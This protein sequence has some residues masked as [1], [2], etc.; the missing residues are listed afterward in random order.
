MKIWKNNIFKGC[1]Y[2]YMD[3]MPTLRAS[4]FLKLLKLK[5][6]YFLGLVW[7]YGISTRVGYLMPNP[8]YSYILD[9]YD[10]WT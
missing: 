6:A 3:N 10:L 1:I 5:C 9:I 7:F 2:L 8:I 4:V